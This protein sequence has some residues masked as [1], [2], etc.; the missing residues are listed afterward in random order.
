MASFCAYLIFDSSTV[1]VFLCLLFSTTISPTPWHVSTGLRVC[2]WMSC[3]VLSKTQV[4]TKQIFLVVQEML[5]EQNPRLLLVVVAS[6]WFRPCYSSWIG[7][8]FS[9]IGVASVRVSRRCSRCHSTIYTQYLSS[10]YERRR[11]FVGMNMHGLMQWSTPA[12]CK[13]KA[14][15]THVQI[16]QPGCLKRNTKQVR[17]G[18][19]CHPCLPIKPAGRSSRST[20]KHFLI[21]PA[22]ETSLYGDVSHLGTHQPHYVVEQ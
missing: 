22:S 3:A 6:E 16:T 4:L 10:R 12:H 11:S 15:S 13:I 21:L 17:S 9:H 18:G 20:G 2:P 7:R 8:S 1:S 5:L 14:K 19:C